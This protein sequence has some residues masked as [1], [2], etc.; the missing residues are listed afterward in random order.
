[1]KE[2]FPGKLG[3]MFWKCSIIDVL[4]L[5]VRKMTLKYWGGT[6]QI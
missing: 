2:L 4:E 3:L 5:H 6:A 1:M